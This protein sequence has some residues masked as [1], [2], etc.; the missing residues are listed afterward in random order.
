MVS[1]FETSIFHMKNAISKEFTL[2][3]FTRTYII[4]KASKASGEMHSFSRYNLIA[5]NVG[6]WLLN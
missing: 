4:I 6:I 1:V 3:I 5:I 2:H